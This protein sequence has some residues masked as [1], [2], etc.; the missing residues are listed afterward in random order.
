MRFTG[1]GI[2]NDQ[3]WVSAPEFTDLENNQS[4]SHLVATDQDSFNI[5]IGGTPERIPSALV[6]TSFFP[7]LGVQA[8]VGRVF[9]AEEG[10][11]GREHVVLLGLA[12][13]SSERWAFRLK[14][15]VAGEFCAGLS[16]H[17]RRS[18]ECT[19]TGINSRLFL[20]RLLG[21]R[22]TRQPDTEQPSNRPQG[23]NSALPLASASFC[24][25]R[26]PLP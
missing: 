13:T 6:S 26:R 9:L 15:S 7:M 11:P 24:C 4:L 23:A 17:H 25:L 3:N 20:S 12:R 22:L 5:N 10:H 19:E 18:G 2:P 8:Q 16:G 21:V 14:S 1:I